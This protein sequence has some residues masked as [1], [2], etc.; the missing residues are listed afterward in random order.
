MILNLGLP[1]LAAIVMAALARK[2]G[3]SR[4]LCAGAILPVAVIVL[5]SG[6]LISE[7]LLRI[8][9]E[10]WAGAIGFAVFIGFL[11]LLHSG[12]IGKEN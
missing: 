3:A 4:W 5:L 7:K 10:I 8:D 11:I 2:G 1:L 12:W 9:G 6:A